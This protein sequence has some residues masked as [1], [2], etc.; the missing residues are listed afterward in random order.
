L[1]AVA[2]SGFRLPRTYG[3]FRDWH[4]VRL[5]NPPAAELYRLTFTANA[6]AIALI[7]LVA[8]GVFYLLRPRTP[9]RP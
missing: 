9:P 5:A 6:V 1:A 4:E 8:S 3:A 2:V 7:L